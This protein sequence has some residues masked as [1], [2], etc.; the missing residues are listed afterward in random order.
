MNQETKDGLQDRLLDHNYD[1][2]QEYDNPMPGW[3]VLFFWATIIFS[4]L[5]FANV[6]PGLGTGK[7][8]IANYEA[9]MAKAREKYAQYQTPANA[10]G[11]DVLLA[12]VPDKGKVEE[13]KA[14]FTTTCAACHRADAGGLIGPNLT[15]DYWIHGNR[16]GDIWR[17]VNGGVLDKGMPAW[18]QVLKPEQVNS[19][20]AYVISLHGTNPE[21]P[22]APQGNLMTADGTLDA[23]AG[24]APAPAADRPANVAH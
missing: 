24:T 6:I 22:K 11:D 21:N 16:P 12:L 14:T 1:G 19:V 5:Y 17:T 10:P 20:V 23:G 18:G 8:K 2:I 7:G 4:V 13:G 9:E 15:D 3:W